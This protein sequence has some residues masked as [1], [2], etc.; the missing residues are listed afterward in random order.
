MKWTPLKVLN[1]LNI[2][3]L[4]VIVTALVVDLPEWLVTAAITIMAVRVLVRLETACDTID[5]LQDVWGGLKSVTIKTNEI[6]FP[7]DKEAEHDR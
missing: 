1:L 6:H 4:V 2:P 5:K 7:E 3:V